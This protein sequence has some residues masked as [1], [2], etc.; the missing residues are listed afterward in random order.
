MQWVPVLDHLLTTA[1]LARILGISPSGVR[2]ARHEGRLPPAVVIGR[3]VYW[4]PSTIE[5]WLRERERADGETR[6]A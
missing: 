5:R 2:S 1:D 4:R 6:Q 3:R